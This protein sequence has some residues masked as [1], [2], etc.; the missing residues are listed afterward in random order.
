MRFDLCHL[1]SMKSYSQHGEDTFV[2]ELIKDC[3]SKFVVDVGANDGFSWSNS[4]PFIQEGYSAL[5]IEPMPKYAQFCR[6]HHRENPNVFVEEVAILPERGAVKFFVN[7]DTE[8]DL[9][10]MASSV[11]REGILGDKIVEIEVQACPLS[12]LLL[13]YNVPRDYAFLSV[14]AEGVDVEV[15]KTADLGN[16]RPHVIC[17]EHGL[18]EATVKGY[19]EGEGY[20]LKQ[21]LGANGIYVPA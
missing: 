17:V 9:L 8:R 6:E 13:K 5:L 7:E 4:Y 18:K 16:Y 10:S 15:L 21:V 20:T 3:K 2:R 12:E 19:L 11:H 14:D 1:S